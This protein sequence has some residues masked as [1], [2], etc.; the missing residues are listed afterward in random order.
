MLNGMDER[1][2]PVWGYE[3]YYEASDQ[4]RV[5]S[6]DRWTKCGQRGSGQMLH[7]GRVLTPTIS[8][9]DGRR[10][11]WLSVHGNRKLRP[12]APLVLEAFAGPRPSPNIDCCHNDGDRA[13]DALSN[14]R[15][16]TKKANYADMATHGTNFRANQTHCKRGHELVAPNLAE[17][18]RG[19]SCRACFDTHHWA[20]SRDIPKGDHR[21]LAESNRRYVL[22]MS[23]QYEKSPQAECLRGHLLEAPNLA[24]GPNRRCL[25]CSNTRAWAYYYDIPDD[26]PRWTAEADRRYAVV[27]AGKK[28]PSRGPGKKECPRGHRLEAPNLRTGQ[29]RRC[30]AC[31]GAQS[32]AYGRNIP[33]SDPRWAAEADRRYAQIMA[34][35]QVSG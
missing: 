4:G 22:I 6:L 17:G 21:W 14:L 9:R 15:W 18:Q 8:K 30:L 34:L 23:G 20:R 12:V 16:D 27:M 25:T 35:P 7:K 31:S 29:A 32:W 19:R 1:W 10:R 13:N 5:R 11:V 24:G 26:D 2:Q 33:P 3:G 28:R